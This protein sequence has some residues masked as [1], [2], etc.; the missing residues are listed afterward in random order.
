[1]NKLIGKRKM[2]LFLQDETSRPKSK[3]GASS[4]LSPLIAHRPIPVTTGDEVG[5]G[6][7][8]EE[9]WTKGD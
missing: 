2:V 7:A 8:G 9:A 3:T 6:V 5:Q 4:P 1:L